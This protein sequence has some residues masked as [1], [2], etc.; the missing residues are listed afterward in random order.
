MSVCEKTAPSAATWG[1]RGALTL[2]FLANGAATGAWAVLQPTLKARLE[3][4]DWELSNALLAFALG[5]VL[6]MPL[7][8]MV[9]PRVGPGRT[10]IIAGLAFSLSLAFVPLTQGLIGLSLVALLL[11]MSSSTQSVAMNA[12]GSRLENRWGSPIMSSLHGAYSAG[13]LAGASLGGLLIEGSPALGAWIPAALVVGVNLLS[14]AGLGIG[15]RSAAGGSVF[16][17]PERG[18]IG[19]CI[20]ILFGVLIES[21]MLNWSAV[22]LTGVVGVSAGVAAMGFMGYSL[23]MAAL[24]LTGDIF[25]QSQ[26]PVRVV[27]FGGVLAT[28]G[29]V[30]VAFSPV[31]ELTLVGF[32]L[33]GMGLGNIAPTAFGAAS[34][35]TASPASGVAMVST[36]AYAAYIIGPPVIGGVATMT[37]LRMGM[38]V[39]VASGVMVVLSAGAMKAAK[40]V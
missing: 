31:F 34:R 19:L 39:L 1:E 27:L 28:A 33:T 40:P 35:L 2:S 29:L 9:S 13:A 24:R 4:S 6:A 12:Y 10:A 30:L 17:P 23:G 3:L 25:V 38:A 18:M 20:L 5:S 14:A 36:A 21:S 32:V 11:G 15:E 16:A 7:A 8:A 37:D 26:G 22:Y